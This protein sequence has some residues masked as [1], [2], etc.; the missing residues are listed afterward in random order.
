MSEAKAFTKEE[1]TE[2]L[3]ERCEDS[4]LN[5][6]SHRADELRDV[7]RW[8]ATLLA[9]EAERDAYRG[10]YEWWASNRES[11]IDDFIEEAPLMVGPEDLAACVK[12]LKAIRAVT[13]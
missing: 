8:D 7:E 1:R 5:M 12:A 2:M 11:D 13:P 9:V 4:L 6:Y 3:R 10:F